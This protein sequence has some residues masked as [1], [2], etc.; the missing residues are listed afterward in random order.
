MKKNRNPDIMPL[1][2]VLLSAA[3]YVLRSGLY[4]TALD[5]KNLL[6]R[7]HPLALC[8]WGCTAAAFVLSLVAAG[9]GY[10]ISQYAANF[11]G[12]VMAALGH[13][14]AG[15]GI[16]LTVL[17][18]PVPVLD[19]AATL[20]KVCGI[21]SCAALYWAAFSRAR[22]DRPFFGTYGVMSVFFA[23]HL[24]ANYQLWCADPQ[25]QN[26]VFAF[27]ACLMLMLFAYYQ[28]AFCVDSGSSFRLR[29]TGLLA[30]FFCVC[31]IAVQGHLWLYGG[32]AVWAFTG[33]SRIRPR[34]EKK[35]GEVHGSA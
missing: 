22:G 8:L 33:L 18:D 24:I 5:D 32:C 9:Q 16:L 27:L 21:L 2:I 6:L 11:E 31:A 1:G 34:R 35:A 29:F 23:I 25:L 3:G 20:W 17:L 28:C 13:I 19:P 10:K 12:S 14:L 30:V 4:T 15:S 7:N 26:F